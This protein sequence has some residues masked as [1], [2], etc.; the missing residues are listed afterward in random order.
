[1]S[2]PSLCGAKTRAGTPCKKYPMEGKKR[3]MLHGGKSTGAKTRAGKIKS[4]TAPI[5]SGAYIKDETRNAIRD[6]SYSPQTIFGKSF[7]INAQEE[8]FSEYFFEAME[9]DFTIADRS[10]L[11][12]ANQIA[13]QIIRGL[14]TAAQKKKSWDFSRLLDS[15]N[16]TL[17]EMN[18]TRNSK[19][20][21]ET[22]KIDLMIMIQNYINKQ[23]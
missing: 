9:K 11:F 18:L 5:K 16:R 14:S 20:E 19:T 12:L 22:N 4:K 8:E 3:C 21:G 13:I 2:K 7:C 6:T 23:D 17:R 10:Q 1:M 15:F